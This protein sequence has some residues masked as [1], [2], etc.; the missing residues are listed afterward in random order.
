MNQEKTNDLSR[1]RIYIDA[2]T[3]EA[4]SFDDRFFNFSKPLLWTKPPCS[5]D[6]WFLLFKSILSMHSCGVLSG[7]LGFALGTPLDHGCAIQLVTAGPRELNRAWF[8]FGMCRDFAIW[9]VQNGGPFAGLL[10][11]Y[12]L[13]PFETWL[14]PPK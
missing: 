12:I 10:K 3:G 1:C 14:F 9:G 8:L 2:R 7:S 6:W 13:Q 4:N 11:R 5:R